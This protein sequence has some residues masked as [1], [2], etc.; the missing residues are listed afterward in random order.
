MRDLHLNRK[1][2]LQ[3][4][5]PALLLSVGWTSVIL[6]YTKGGL[7]AGGDLTDFFDVTNILKSI[8]PDGSIF[9]LALLTTSSDIYAAFYIA[10]AT[11]CFLVLVAMIYFTRA[12]FEGYLEGS[13]LTFAAIT[14]AFFYLLLPL[15]FY[16]TFKSLVS[17]VLI[18]N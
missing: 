12:I 17:S 7:L 3:G 16:D 5:L 15:H 9:A 10:L 2:L 6:A 13:H 14:A 4:I 18:P 1:V 8:T 11:D